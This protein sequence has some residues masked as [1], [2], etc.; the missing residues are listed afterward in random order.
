MKKGRP[1]FAKDLIET[2]MKNKSKEVDEEEIISFV[3]DIMKFVRNND[4]GDY[5]TN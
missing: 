2:L 1:E 3:E 4:D 5:K